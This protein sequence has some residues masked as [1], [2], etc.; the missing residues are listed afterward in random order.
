MKEKLFPVVDISYLSENFIESKKWKDDEHFRTDELIRELAQQLRAGFETW[1]FLYIKGHNI[2]EK[3][4]TDVFTE[5]KDFFDKPLASKW[6]YNRGKG[7]NEGY[8]GPENEVFDID[9]PLDMKQAF[10]FRPNT[11]TSTR[12]LKESPNFV[13]KMTEL[14]A[15]CAELALQFLRLLAVA[16]GIDT[17]HFASFHSS[18]GNH[19]NN[20]TS[21][22]SLYYPSINESNKSNYGYKI[23][24]ASRRCREHTDYGTITLLFQDQAGGLE[25]CIL[26]YNF[27]RFIYTQRLQSSK[28]Q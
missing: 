15:Y 11:D 16:L 27:P 10:D 22:R 20:G 1:G 24:D 28:L 5:S 14:F 8:V 23:T 26:F 21:L 17:E 4:V 19:S 3:L 9:K 18:L 12:L 6:I 13:E 2:P 25:V 7:I